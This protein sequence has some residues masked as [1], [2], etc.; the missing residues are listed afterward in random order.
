M[1]V[2]QTDLVEQG[3]SNDVEEVVSEAEQPPEYEATEVRNSPPVEAASVVPVFADDNITEPSSQ[4]SQFR[5]TTCSSSSSLS[6]ADIPVT[7]NVL[8]PPL[9]KKTDDGMQ[10]CLHFFHHQRFGV[11][12]AFL[13][14]LNLKPN[15]IFPFLMKLTNSII[16]FSLTAFFSE[17]QTC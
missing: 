15:L 3:P 10:I 14:T 4:V 12:L 8:L 9:I 2:F 16:K 6:S 13:A 7:S 11:L 5:P 17:I 1:T